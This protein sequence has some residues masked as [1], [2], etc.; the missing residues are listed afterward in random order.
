MPVSQV[1][2]LKE[3]VHSKDLVV[4]DRDHSLRFNDWLI[5]ISMISCKFGELRQGNYLLF[6]IPWR[7]TGFC[8]QILSA[9]HHWSYTHR[10]QNAD[11]AREN[12]RIW[13]N[14]CMLGYACIVFACSCIINWT[15][16]WNVLILTQFNLQNSI[17][18]R[19]WKW[20]FD[21]WV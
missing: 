19:L 17:F 9:K 3:F 8:V 18:L 21:W 4:S 6:R 7:V 2:K 20:Y 14:L 1:C 12:L 16:F 13:V 11:W 10:E 5:L 15:C